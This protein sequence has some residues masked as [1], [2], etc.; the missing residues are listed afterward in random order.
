MA[1]KHQEMQRIIRMYRHETGE[2]EVDMHGVAKFAVERLGWSLPKPVDPYDRLTTQFS[3][4]ARVEV[5]YDA[6]DR[7]PLPCKS[8]DCG[9]T[10]GQSTAIIPVVRS[11]RD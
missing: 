8:C 6:K 5:K 4:A 11:R 9:R 2:T 10:G 7:S 1:N 3:Q